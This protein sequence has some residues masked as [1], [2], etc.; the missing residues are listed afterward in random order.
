MVEESVEA[1]NSGSLCSKLATVAF[2]RGNAALPEVTGLG[3]A[4]VEDMQQVHLWVASTQ[5]LRSFDVT[6]HRRS[7]RVNITWPL[8]DARVAPVGLGPILDD[9][10][11][12]K[13]CSCVGFPS[14]SKRF[15]LS[16]Y[17]VVD[18]WFSHLTLTFRIPRSESEREAEAASAEKVSRRQVFI[19]GK[20]DRA[21]YFTH[22]DPGMGDYNQS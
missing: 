18:C 16:R 20:S 19:L 11:C 5:A 1:A 14:K 2:D 21:A 7:Q 22:E 12:E 4:E 6:L 13:N 3:F 8:G 17:V 10:G 9:Q 15:T